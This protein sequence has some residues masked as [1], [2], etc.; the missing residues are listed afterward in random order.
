ME[1]YDHK[2]IEATWQAFWEKKGLYDATD[3]K[4]ADS[5]QK[6]F[7]GLIEFPYPS[8]DGLHVGHIRSNTAMD[9]ISR[10]RRREGYEVLYP[11]GWDAFG[12]PT[13][14]YA[15][16]TGIQ[17]ALVTKTNTDTFRRQLKSIGFSFDWNREIN[18]T[19]PAYYKWTQWIFLQFLKEG[20]AYKKKMTIN[21][22][23]K[24]LIGL[25]NEEVV[26]GKCERCG[27]VVEKREKEQWMLAITKY[28][29][30]LLEGLDSLKPG[31]P[32]ID[33]TTGEFASR[34]DKTTVSRS[35]SLAIIK[36]WEKDEYLCLTSKKH[37]WTTFVIGG[38]ESGE[39]A[40]DCAQREIVEETGY[41]DI[42]F[43]RTLGSTVF[44]KH[45]A[46]HKDVNRL[47]EVHGMYFELTG[48]AHKDIAAEEADHQKVVWVSRADMEKALQPKITDWVFW[49][50]FLGKKDEEISFTIP[51]QPLLDWPAS[52]KDSQRN[53]IGKSEGAEI[54]FTLSGGA[55]N[56]AKIKV[57]TTRPDTLFGVTYVVLA[58]E[59]VLVRDL[60]S[61]A[62]NKKEIE[63]YIV[64]TK[65]E[66]D[67]E[68]TDATSEKTGVELT[69]VSAINPVNGE[70]IPVWISDYVLADYGTGAVMAVPAHDER[71][72][73]FAQK[74]NL[75]IKYVIAPYFLDTTENSKPRTEA[76][77]KHR[78]IAVSVVKHW[79]EN[80]YLMLDWA[81]GW[82]GFITGGIEAGEDQIKA[83]QREIKEETGY[84][85]ARHVTSLG[86]PVLADFYA[87]HKKINMNVET[88]GIYF[89]LVDG[90]QEEVVDAEKAIHTPK[91]VSEKE[92]AAFFRSGAA[93]GDI[94]YCELAWSRKQTGNYV[95]S[96]EGHLVNSG[97]FTGQSSEHVKKKITDVAGGIWVTKFKL[98]DWVFSRQRYWGEPIPVVHC[99]KCGIVPLPESELPL[100]LP[101]VKN[102][103]PTETGESPLAAISEWVNTTC[104]NCVEENK[105]TKY[106][107]FDFDGV[108]GDTW[109]ATIAAKVAIGD[110]SST[111]D[112]V[113]KTHAY[114]EK[115]PED[116]RNH[117]LTD[118]Q[119]AKKTEWMSTFGEHMSAI[120]FTLFDD[121][122]KE[123]KKYKNVKL[124]V[125][126]AGSSKYVLPALKK[127]GL[128]FSHILAYEDH[129]SKE[130][131]VE[132]VCH[133]WKVD[134]KDVYY[135]TDTKADVYE[136][137]SIL[138]PQKIVGCA[139]GFLGK[140]KLAEV[141]PERQILKDFTDIHRF[142][143]T[144]CTARRETD[145]MPNW[146]GSSWYYLRYIDPKNAKAF[147]AADKLKYW[148][149]VDWYNGG[150]EHTTL[151]LLYSR[152]WHKFLFD[153]ALVPTSEPYTKRTAHG[154]I[155]AKG[156][157]KMSKSKGNVI[158]PDGIV[159]TMGADS[160][161]LY[162][163]FMGPFDQA[164]AWDENG[165]VGCR[166]FIERV[167]KL[168]GKIIS[169]A[170]SSHEILIN[171]T[172]KKV[173]EDIESMRFNTAVS[174]LMIA[175]NEFE[176]EGIAAGHYEILLGLLAPFAPHVTEELWQQLFAKNASKKKDAKGTKIVSI[177]QL[178]WPVFDPTKIKEAI[179]TI[180]IQINGKTRAT[181]NMSP[182]ASEDEVKNMALNMPEIKKWLSAQGQNDAAGH[183]KLN[184]K[185]VIYVKGRLLNLVIDLTSRQQNDTTSI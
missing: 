21:W 118:V 67:I 66:T 138:D 156:G 176:K 30:K 151:H 41:T 117:S 152:F 28:A 167:W 109:N 71:D 80:K 164:I 69:G 81:N 83:A 116:S 48:P 100:K 49:Q 132:M 178:P 95:W 158:N 47:S 106:F 94:R 64:A 125:V 15:I 29:D 112:A 35:S 105:K 26:D 84:L 56:G 154:L 85:N 155:L 96:D 76:E 33:V 143:N 114:F 89:E 149:P 121:F 141:L 90:A 179:V 18:T 27:T 168:S 111:E 58:P 91:W 145:T 39:N 171:K 78:K 61:S 38:I 25:A 53:W 133:D 99:D 180:P 115:K 130:E 185:K 37:G 163:M 13:E 159:A 87:P 161:R 103:K 77:T 79:S 150:M 42:T 169:T 12:L 52:I 17:P 70:R 73:A 10:K 40:I 68:R 31:T 20:L 93:K 136:L 144:D 59:H 110:A 14:N 120:D 124:A 160:L 11:I 126:S 75:P 127:S 72:W 16:K 60:I 51:P 170:D 34:P 55:A 82:T 57:F 4:K 181:V 102:Y 97:A 74:Y 104:P 24:D 183:E 137:N 175:L 153:Q 146:A 8:G 50:R 166:R 46:P 129:H 32:L 122:I 22:C 148:T 43:I 139:W 119:M 134:I 177:H 44:A 101:E 3:P 88:Y 173:S 184:I 63:A 5:M 62:Q 147:A 98:R 7:Y 19:D 157:E 36:H 23:P 54:E 92:V 45:F 162:E 174:T 123:V 107:I 6:K 131:K 108:L 2:K 182:G 86:G 165:I 135:F 128:K 1:P 65:K 9:I 113:V 140:E 172:I 142:F